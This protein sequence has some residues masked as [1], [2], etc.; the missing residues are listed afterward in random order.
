MSAAFT[1]KSGLFN[2]GIPLLSTTDCAH[3]LFCKESIEDVSHFLV[4]CSEFRD[5]FES[6]CA[7]LNRKI[8]P[9][10]P[11]D[12]AQV[13]SFINS[14]DRQRKVLLLLEE[15][16]LPFDQSTATLTTRFVTT[17]ICEITAWG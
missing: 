5:N 6:V 2:G 9:S 3:C 8:M 11:N 12:G 17:A 15:L 7:N 16:R 10:N 4:D 14:L 1:F 13:A